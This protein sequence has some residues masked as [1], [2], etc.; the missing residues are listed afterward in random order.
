MFYYAAL[1]DKSY[2]HLAESFEYN[3][4]A[5]ELTVNVRKGAEW[6]DGTPF[7]ADDIVFTYNTLIERAP[8]YRDSARIATLLDRAEAVDDHTVKFFLKSPNYR[9]HF[10]ECTFRMDRGIYLVP[11]HVFQDIEDW[12]EFTFWDLEKGW[13]V[14]TGAYR[15]SESVNTHLH[16]DRLPEWWAVKTGFFDAMPEVERVLHIPFTDDTKAAQFTIQGDVDFTLDVRPRT[17]KTIMDQN[18][19]II[20]H[21]FQDKPYGYV[22]WW[23]ISVHINNLEEPYTDP[24][25]RWAIAYAIDQE[26][27]LEIGWDGAGK[28]S[29]HPYPEYPRLMGY[30]ESVQDIL[31]EYNPLEFNLQKSDDLMKGA[32]FEKDAEGFWAKGGERFDA[33]LWAGVPLFGDIAPVIAEQLRTAGFDSTHVTPPDVWAGKNDGRAMLH[34]FG[35]GGSVWDP[36]T[37]LDMYHIREV[38]PTGEACGPNRSRWANEEY[39]EIVDEYSATPADDPK[40]F[41]LFRSAIEIWYKNL[42]EVPM[43]QWYHRIP[44]NTRYWDNW[45][46]RDN[47]YNTALWHIT[48][49]ITLWN[50]KSKG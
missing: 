45:P 7:T 24:N 5:T 33:N 50:L 18:P 49:D 17:I 1:D 2:S 25:V 8:D 6:S 48:M 44:M 16:V 10:T 41:D 4:D 31:D 22:D 12:R 28:T 34:L 19:E 38:K 30:L 42:P 11:K 35:H 21:T 14:V 13:P 15:P 40:T 46:T 32:G 39:S 37:T 29:A 23:P 20:S 26:Q 43:L 9:F 36:Y 3:D 47:P 27:V